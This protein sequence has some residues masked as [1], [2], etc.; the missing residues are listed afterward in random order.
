MTKYV[1]EFFAICLKDDPP[2]ITG[3]QIAAQAERLGWNLRSIKNHTLRALEARGYKRFCNRT[4]NDGLFKLQGQLTIVYVKGG[5]VP[6]IE[7]MRSL[8]M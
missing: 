7:H 6:S 2:M 4:R 3:A 1:E 8:G 5:F